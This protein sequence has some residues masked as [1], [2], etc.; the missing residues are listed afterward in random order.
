MTKYA[1]YNLWANQTLVEWL[2]SKPAELWDQEV[3]SSFSSIAKT[4]V[5][6]WDTERFWLSVLKGV[7][8]PPSFRFHGYEGTAAE[9]MDQ[10]IVQSQEF[11]AY[12]TTLWESDLEKECFLDTPWVK[13][14]LPRFEFIHHCLN[15][16]TYHRGQLITIG[17]NVELTDAPMTDYNF[18]NMVTLKAH[19]ER[20]AIAS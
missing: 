7:P 11:E 14:T 19:E 18:Y 5:H 16:S 4:I 17:R 6:I 2:K 20:V 10:L 3:P 1:G 9:A 13:G 12:V 15:H 8:P